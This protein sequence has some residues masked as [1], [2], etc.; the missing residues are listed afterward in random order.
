MNSAGK[1]VKILFAEDLPADAELARREIKK[2]GIDFIYKVVDTEPEFRKKLNEFNPDI[3]V[4]DYSM[5]TFDGMLALTI[6][7]KLSPF[8]PFIILTGS[9][10]EETAVAC[11]KA[12]AND[13]VIK[14]QITR[15]PFAVAEALSKSQ[16]KL[17]KDLL[18]NQL[19]ENEAMYRSLIEN[20]SDAIYLLYEG[21]FEI[22]N[23]EFLNMFGY[24]FE[25][26]N[27]PG[28]EPLDLVA[29]DSK[30]F[31]KERRRR[32]L[33]GEK[34]GNR[35]EFTAILKNGEK[36][37]V[38]ASVSYINFK[39]GIAT[40]GIIRDITEKKKM[41]DNLVAAKEK[42]EE[43]DRLKSAFLANMSHEI[44]TPMN[45][46]MGFTELLKEPKLAGKEK[47][48]YIK[49]IQKSGQRMLSTINDLIEISKIESGS[50]ELKLTEVNVNDQLDYLYNF[51]KPETENKGLSFKLHKRLPDEQ[52]VVETDQE[53]LNGVLVNLI[54]NAI[55]Y[56]DQG[57]IEMG[58]R[59]VDY[60]LYF[61]VKDT[62]IG[63]EEKHRKIIFDRFAQA[64]I[65]L[66]KPYEGAGLGLS[67]AKAYVEMLGGK[68]WLQSEPEEGTQFF[69]SIPFVQEQSK[70]Q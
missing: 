25:E 67:I 9:M 10:N 42:A 55:K 70:K 44:R 62:G 23:T 7:R 68:I 5:P 57:E 65:S 28:F 66:S 34:V 24:S 16:A 29:H 39:G 4:S 43:S 59:L 33:Q 15:L 18:Q 56:T 20:S 6:T 51:F 19:H 14:E 64:D 38:E 50:L 47:K 49:I 22:I 26:L 46:I 13:Y 54:K 41:I 1:T 69:F 37:E 3:V 60:T 2:G 40:Q 61:F 63:I 52:A 17:E 12:G 8:L 58:C 53:K 36:R 11:M 32:V 21:K 45:G 27:Q 30:P 35:Y 31:V 48:K